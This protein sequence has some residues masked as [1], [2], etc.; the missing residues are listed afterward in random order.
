MHSHLMEHKDEV[1]NIFD[2]FMSNGIVPRISIN[3]KMLASRNAEGIHELTNYEF[4]IIK[5]VI[6]EG[7]L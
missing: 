2:I 4:S 5:E 1:Y 6:K 3:E 7:K